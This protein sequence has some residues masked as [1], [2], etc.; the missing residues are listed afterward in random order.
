MSDKNYAELV[1]FALDLKTLLSFYVNY[2]EG[3]ESYDDRLVWRMERDIEAL[4]NGED[5]VDTGTEQD[6][7]G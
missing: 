6:H 7:Q 1:R 3:T 4:E 5:H 2:S